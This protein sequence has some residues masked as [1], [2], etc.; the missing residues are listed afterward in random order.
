VAGRFA[1]TQDDISPRLRRA[2]AK[3]DAFLKQATQYHAL[4]AEAYARTTASWTD[5]TGA[6][7]SGL[8]AE[9]NFAGS[10]Y[11]IDVYHLAPYGIWLEVRFAGRYAVINPTIAHE[12]PL[13]RDT[14]R[15]L[16]S[17]L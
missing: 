17:T 2:P 12:G 9:P 15:K 6:A 5:R 10:S 13:F 16:L 4:R 11:A 8:S 1:W 14:C 7:R 3:A